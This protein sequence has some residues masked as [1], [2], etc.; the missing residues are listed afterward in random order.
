MIVIALLCTQASAGMKPTMSEVVV[1]Q[2][3]SLVEHL[4]PTMHVFVE[5]N[6]RSHEGHSTST[7]SST[8]NATAS[9]S[10]L[11]ARLLYGAVKGIEP[12]RLQ[13][14][15]EEGYSSLIPI[16]HNFINHKIRKYHVKQS[17]IRKAQAKS[18]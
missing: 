13:N 4:Q 2:T 6:L 17:S 12:K 15:P 16:F 1:L 18:K 8:S 7:G 14:K 3:R 11:S 9:V 5:T 10:V